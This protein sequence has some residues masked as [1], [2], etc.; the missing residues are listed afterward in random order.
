M[1]AQCLSSAAEVMLLYCVD[2]LVYLLVTVWDF[3]EFSK[4]LGELERDFKMA[5]L[6]SKHF[7][8]KYPSPLW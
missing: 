1:K 3:M 2:K 5:K 7:Y 6:F 8:S 4:M